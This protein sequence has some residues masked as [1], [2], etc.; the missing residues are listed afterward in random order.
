MPNCINFVNYLRV[1]QRGYRAFASHIALDAAT[2]G[3]LG[4]AAFWPF[5][6]E[7]YFLPWRPIRVSPLNPR[8]FM[9][10]RGLAVLRSGFLWVWLPV[11]TRLWL[12]RRNRRNGGH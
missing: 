2:N 5:S 11:T 7:R 10:E 8:V 12:L 3:G 4:V 9:S 1:A 6:D